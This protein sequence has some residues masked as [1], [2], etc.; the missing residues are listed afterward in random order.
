ME[1]QKVLIK[2]LGDS[3]VA[4]TAVTQCDGRLAGRSEG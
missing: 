1:L 4:Q 3:S 2:G